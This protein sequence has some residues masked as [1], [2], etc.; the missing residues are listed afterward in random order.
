[1]QPAFAPNYP[2][3]DVS[4]ASPGTN[5]PD[6]EDTYLTSWAN[7]VSDISDNIQYV[8]Q[9]T[10]ASLFAK[11][12]GITQA[13]TA[14]K[15]TLLGYFEPSIDMPPRIFVPLTPYANVLGPT[16]TSDE[17]AV[18]TTFESQVIS[19][20]RKALIVAQ[21][22][23]ARATKSRARRMT[24]AAEDSTFTSSTTPQGL[25]SH[26]L[27]GGGWS[28]LNLAQNN[29][30]GGSP[31]YL[32]PEGESP[33]DPSQYQLSFINLSQTLQSAF[34]TNQQFLVVTLKDSLGSLFSQ[35]GESGGQPS[36]DPV[37]NNKMSIEGWPFDLNVGIDNSY[38][39][40]KN[41]LIFK[42]CEG[43]L[44]DRAK[45]PKSW[46]QADTFN[47]PSGTG[48]DEAYQQIVSISSWIQD[49]IAKAESAYET[50]LQNPATNQAILFEKFHNII[51]DPNWNGILALKVDV[52]LQ[53]FP[54]Q[55]KGLISGINL[56]NFNAHH[57]GI[58][59]NKVNASGEIKMEKN[60]SLF[61]LINYL[62]PVYEGQLIQGLN[63]EKPVL[64]TPG[65]TYEFKVLQLQVLFENTAIKFFQSKVQVTMNE[66][67]SDTVIGTNYP[68]QAGTY[69]TVVLDGTYQDHKDSSEQGS[70]GTPVYVFENTLD[71]LFYFDS[72]LLTNVEIIKIQFSTL[73]TDP[74]ATEIQ[75]RFTMWGYLNF[76]PL[77]STVPGVDG[78][79]SV[80][81]TLDA[82]SFGN[83]D[84]SGGADITRGLSYSN[85]YLEMSFNLSTPTIVDFTFDPGQIVFNSNQSETRP[86]SLYPNFALQVNNLVI[87]NS[88]KLP[89][90]LGYLTISTPGLQTSGLPGDWYGLEMTL[91]MG[92]PGELA[93]SLDFNA[94]L[95]LAWSPG[96]KASTDIYNAVVG[97]KLPGTSSNAKLMSLQGVLKLAIG[98]LKLEYEEAQKSYLLTLSDIAL[99][100]LGL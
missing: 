9:P 90:K 29:V 94:S 63:P 62:D 21:N 35:S 41:V 61:G 44:I 54:Q 73:T 86:Y 43:T 13:T 18:Y 80:T 36:S 57:F 47:V 42:F 56:K 28:L 50:G 84:G 19:K 31:E 74:D 7:V 100:F 11:N 58:E 17:I 70:S 55:L 68:Y 98:T 76:A 81:T 16:S 75:S 20:R 38:A 32:Y 97:I 4:L 65:E 93:A 96:T 53:E 71:N 85:L 51:H 24:L 59:I 45:N 22:T 77:S 79:E 49:Y 15:A 89:S 3:R 92:T 23:T 14:G 40:Y 30:D 12:E 5:N 72:N 91:N 88:E 33:T 37:F 95:L 25:I 6:L 39:D 66:L 82:F 10:G 2:L 48:S 34:L 83:G 1:K 67:F 8:S 52:D 64:P 99:K 69:N 87:G 26:V 60:S 78:G 46:T 27:H